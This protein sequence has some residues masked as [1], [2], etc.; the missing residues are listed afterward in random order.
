MYKIV[1]AHLHQTER[2]NSWL[3]GRILDRI[4]LHTFTNQWRWGMVGYYDQSAIQDHQ[5]FTCISIFLSIY[6]S[7]AHIPLSPEAHAAK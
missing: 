7:V 4:T 2:P 6:L 5:I 1:R 3:N